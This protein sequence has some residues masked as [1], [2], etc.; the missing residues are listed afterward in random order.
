MV[1]DFITANSM[2][3]CSLFVAEVVQHTGLPT[4][5]TPFFNQRLSVF[6]GRVNNKTEANLLLKNCFNL[7]KIK[8]KMN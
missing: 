1:S 8:E 5:V 6:F 4:I 3:C 2:C 7:Q